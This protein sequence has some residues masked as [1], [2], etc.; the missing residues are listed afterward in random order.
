MLSRD[1]PLPYWREEIERSAKRHQTHQNLYSTG[2]IALAGASLV[3]GSKSLLNSMLRGSSSSST[4]PMNV[5]VDEIHPSDISIAALQCPLHGGP[6]SVSE[7]KGEGG[8]KMVSH[9]VKTRGGVKRKHSSMAHFEKM[10]F[11]EL[12]IRTKGYGTV[13]TGSFSGSTVTGPIGLYTGAV[14]NGLGRSISSSAGQQVF[15]QIIHLSG[16]SNVIGAYKAPHVAVS[17]VNV[18]P[19]TGLTFQ[20]LLQFA[21]DDLQIQPAGGTSATFPNS[22]AITAQTRNAISYCGGKTKHFFMNTT[23]VDVYFEYWI[24]HPKRFLAYGQDPVSLALL[25]KNTQ[26][27]VTYGGTF[28]ISG[29]AVTTEK[30]FGFNS[31]DMLLLEAWNVSKPKSVKIDVGATFTL[32]V[33]HTPF[34]FEDMPSN[35]SLL[36]GLGGDSD[37]TYY[38]FCTQSLCFRVH[39]AVC[40]GDSGTTGGGTVAT[41]NYA[42]AQLAHW[43]DESHTVQPAFFQSQNSVVNYEFMNDGGVP[44]YTVD[45]ETGATV[46]TNI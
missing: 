27:P 2:T 41:I 38:P 4:N 10:M 43:Q 31:K 37:V 22:N 44:L 23:N 36:G 6:V 32:T 19:A 3:Y 45:K 9:H 34:F 17:N 42:P 28:A 5:S 20:G 14:L 16:G 8:V 24:C 13:T 1:R 15:G 30:M 12:R 46:P 35:Y 26:I 33:D 25:S 7:G 40:T 29:I 18:C 39:G 21:K 11:P